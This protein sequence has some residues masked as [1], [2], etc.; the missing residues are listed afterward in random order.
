MSGPSKLLVML[1]LACGSLHAQMLPDIEQFEV[2]NV[3]L[4]LLNSSG[5]RQ[6]VLS[7][8]VARRGR[9]GRVT[10]SG[11]SLKVERGADSITLDAA[12]F[13][14]QPKASRFECPGGLTVDLPDEGRLVVPKGSGE[15]TFT[16]GMHLTMNVEGEATL[17]D[18][19]EGASLVEAS[20]VNPEIQVKTRIQTVETEDESSEQLQLDSFTVRGARGGSMLLRLAHLPSLA[21]DQD[22]SQAVVTVS[23]FGN[24]E[25]VINESERRA[26]LSMLRRARMALDEDA[27]SFEVTSGRLDIAGDYARESADN[28]NGPARLSGLALDASQNVSIRGGEFTGTGGVLRYR[29]FSAHREA[30]IEND[31]SLQLN[32]GVSEDGRIELIDMRAREYI[33][34]LIPVESVSAESASLDSTDQRPG[35]ISTELSEGARVKQFI[36]RQLQWQITGRFIRLHSFRDTSSPADKRYDHTFDGFSEGYSP[37]LKLYGPVPLPLPADTPDASTEQSP[38]LLRASVYGARAEG[39]FVAGRASVDVYGPNVLG[40]MYSDAPLSDLLKVALGLKERALDGE[41]NP[42]PPPRRDGRLVIRADDVL[43]VD[44]ST[45]GQADAQ[46]DARGNVQLDHEPLPRD[47]SNLVT[48]TGDRVMLRVQG[49]AIRSAKVI[50]D[51]ALATIGHDILL[52]REVAVDEIR[53]ALKTSLKGPGRVIVRDPESVAYFTNELDRLPRRPGA[54]EV[55]APDAAWLEFGAVVTAVI[56]DNSRTLEVDSPRYILVRGEFES[57][58]A[59]RTA[60]NDVPELTEPEV[61]QL[62]E[63]QAL[64]AYAVSTRQT[65]SSPRVNFLSL[66]GSA[67]VNSRLDGITARA[68]DAIELS[69]SEIRRVQ[70]APLAIILRGNADI[71]IDDA[72]VFFGEYVQTGVFAYDKSWRLLA[73]DRLEITLRPLEVPGD[74]EGLLASARE[75]IGNALSESRSAYQQLTFARQAVQM[76][77]DLVRGRLRPADSSTYQPWEALDKIRQSLQNLQRAW[78]LEASMNSHAKVEQHIASRSLRRARAVLSGLIDVVG[79]GRVECGFVSSKPGVPPLDI[80]LHDALFTFDGLGQIVNVNASGP[81]VVSRQ[82][83]TIRG[84]TLSR[85][86]D[87]TLTLDGASIELPRDTGVE[88]SGVESVAL[89]QREDKVGNLNQDVERTMVTRV[90]GRGLKVKVTLADGQ[91]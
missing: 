60:I 41:G 43:H 53:Q 29:E 37:L 85:A 16:N 51:D 5:E 54:A 58:R 2:E 45:T 68:R 30:R 33:D 9:D 86:P 27:R 19:P 40:V 71:M 32:Q 31:P 79:F 10:V 23:C 47:D 59:G 6:G 17:R 34:V 52:C 46:L 66:E 76:L 7:G 87:G 84:K 22:P 48:L 64:R 21:E 83:Y 89:R 63:A 25:L 11:A 4:I 78:L 15:I 44:L 8:K 1:L 50:G 70:D 82:A 12:E 65:D 38:E 61:L 72:G 67:Y 49:G 88:V 26:T 80:Q 75:A 57:P 42:V 3:R 74:E 39:E 81:I 36:D 13:I 28:E 55:P 14:Y 69:G 56:S 90:S 20:V 24:I 62:Y 91:E 73:S 18:G 77:E 35:S